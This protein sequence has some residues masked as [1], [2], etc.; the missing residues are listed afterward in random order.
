[1]HFSILMPTGTVEAFV[2]QWSQWY[3]DPSEELYASNI[4]RS[5]TPERILSLFEWK[6]GGSLSRRKLTSAKYNYI[7]RLREV[8]TLAEDTTPGEFLQL[9]HEGG[10]IWRIFW[11]HCWK[12]ERF[13]I[14]DQHVHRAMEYIRARRCGEIPKSDR[15]IVTSYIQANLPFWEKLPAMPDRRVDKALWVFG[16]FLKRF[17]CAP[18]SSA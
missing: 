7:G 1:M 11:L 10:A 5:L 17:P 2:D 6:N 3:S 18:R 12:P 4:G 14:Y 13:P 9:F 8:A 16:R 15:M